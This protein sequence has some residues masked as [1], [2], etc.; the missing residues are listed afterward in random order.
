MVASDSEVP[1]G[2]SSPHQVHFTGGKSVAGVCCEEADGRLR[3]SDN[4]R[5]TLCIMGESGVLISGIPMSMSSLGAE[6]DDIVAQE[7][8]RRTRR[9]KEKKGISEKKALLSP[10]Y[11]VSKR[12]DHKIG[13]G[14]IILLQPL[15][16]CITWSGREGGQE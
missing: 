2:N 16:H 15:H 4:P 8:R 10:A 7:T 12:S 11:E 5:C 9:K 14:T 6:V 13:K 1:D 3:G